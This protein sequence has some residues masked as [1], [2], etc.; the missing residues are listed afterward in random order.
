MA[1]VKVA[2][3]AF[4]SERAFV[5]PGLKTSPNGKQHLHDEQTFFFDLPND[6]QERGMLSFQFNTGEG[7]DNSIDV[8]FEVTVNGGSKHTWMIAG[9]QTY[10]VQL[11]VFSLQP[12][13]NNITFKMTKGGKG[14]P[15]DPNEH[16]GGKG[17][18]TFNDVC[19]TYHRDVVL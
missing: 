8:A 11:H 1:T 14:S 17:I 13:R 16:L 7:T 6:V 2:N 19:L 12:G 4:I 3:F 9:H 15:S 5:L 18:V 10:G